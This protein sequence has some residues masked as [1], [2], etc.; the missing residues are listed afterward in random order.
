MKASTLLLLLIGICLPQIVF[1]QASMSAPEV[2]QPTCGDLTDGSIT[3]TG[4][5]ADD[6]SFSINDEV[7]A[8][9]T[10]PNLG[11]GTYVIKM[12]VHDTISC[13]GCTATIALNTAD[14]PVPGEVVPTMPTNFCKSDGKV[15]IP[16]TGGSS[17]Q[18]N[19]NGMGFGS[20]TSFEGLMQETP[21]AYE[22]QNEDG[23]CFTDG[24]S[25]ELEGLPAVM[26]ISAE[27]IKPTDCMADDGKIIIVANEDPMA[28]LEYSIGVDGQWQSEP[29][30]TDLKPDFYTIAARHAGLDGDAACPSNTIM[31]SIVTRKAPAIDSIRL[32]DPTDWCTKDG[33]IKIYGS[34]GEEDPTY[35]YT[36]DGGDTWQTEMEYLDLVEGDFPI[37]LANYD[38][39]CVQ[40]SGVYVMVEPIMPNLLGINLVHPSDCYAHDG[41]VIL[42][43]EDQGGDPYGYSIRDSSYSHPD[44]PPPITDE[45]LADPLSYNTLINMEQ[46]PVKYWTDR[47]RELDFA[48]TGTGVRAVEFYGLPQGRYEISYRRD[49]NV[50]ITAHSEVDL[51][52]PPKPSISVSPDPPISCVRQT[53]NITI[54]GSGG[55]G[56]YEYTINGGSTWQT[57]SNTFSDLPEGSYG[58]IIRNSDG[59]CPNSGGTVDFPLV[60]LAPTLDDYSF[61]HPTD[62]DALD[63]TISI[64][65]TAG[66]SPA[67]YSVNGST[68]QASPEFTGLGR[69]DYTPMVRN[70]DGTCA[71]GTT[72]IQLMDPPSPTF[73]VITLSNPD[74]GCNQSG[75]MTIGS[76]GGRSPIEYS[77]DGGVTYQ[78]SATFTDLN[79]DTYTIYVKNTDGTCI[80]GPWFIP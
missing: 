76:S 71:Q 25:V 26:V 12:I 73:P 20:A 21:Y 59:T 3:V 57:S 48:E 5:G 70:N 13:T 67:E 31:D 9:G 22:V 55:I 18:I 17:P 6:I 37:M 46:G 7:Q 54:N 1:S 29:V 53:G 2:V 27:F 28:P 58:A 33:M 77:I 35:Q 23:T 51:V 52:D 50:C 42:L 60:P 65:V 19:F 69:G 40:D 34:G 11:N 32:T 10:F 78:T 47:E 24:F 45:V 61:T 38:T 4:S 72:T 56:S 30:F 64:E 39:S 43:F 74:N 63:G 62:C 49:T 8:S 14:R 15:T 36:I 75:S 44:S 80:K 41:K 16:I 68:W 79:N 66:T